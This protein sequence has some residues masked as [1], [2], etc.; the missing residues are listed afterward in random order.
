MAKLLYAR[1][2]KRGEWFCQSC[3]RPGCAA[4]VNGKAEHKICECAQPKWLVRN[5]TTGRAEMP[6]A[7]WQARYPELCGSLPRAA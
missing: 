4:V 5:A 6:D 1:T 7:V 2:V 3:K